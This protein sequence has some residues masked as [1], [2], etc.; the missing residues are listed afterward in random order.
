MSIGS[1]K[2]ILG[3]QRVGQVVVE[4]VH[5]MKAAIKPGITTHELDA[6][7]R[8]VLQRHGA[9]PA[10]ELFFGYPGATCISINEEVAHAIPGGRRI[11]SGDLVNIDVSAELDDYVADTG[12]SIPV[13]QVAPVVQPL[14]DA[15]VEALHAALQV[16]RA[17]R[18]MAGVREAFERVAQ[19]R[20]FTIIKNLSGHGVGRHLHEEPRY[21][22]D[23]TRRK[24]RR[25]FHK[26]MVLTLEPFLSTGAHLATTGQDG[27]TLLTAKGHYTAQYE[28]TIIITE[29]RPIVVTEGLLR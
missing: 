4:A 1:K 15:T 22:P 25:R 8:R 27:W 19:R 23:F 7:G 29:S 26:G 11:R 5:E 28:H 20:G 13:G 2:D 14:C 16:A 21:V 6:I 24:D 3:L 17:G 18:P 10:P 12:A 9:R